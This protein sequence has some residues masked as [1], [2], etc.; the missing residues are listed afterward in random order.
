M[1]DD[2]A[3]WAIA[4]L[5]VVAA[6]GFVAFWIAWLRADHDTPQLPAGYVD[7]E[8][9]FLFTDSV[10][11]VLLLVGAVL[12]I[13]EEPAGGSLGLVTGGMLA[14][15]AIIDGAYF[16]RTGM[17]RRE[18]GGAVNAGIVVSIGLLALILIVRFF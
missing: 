1:T 4:A 3:V 16:A 8:T 14:F 11:V 15:L 5:E 12:Q 7:H 17:F 18:Q 13:L 2:P 9:P 10:I 6:G